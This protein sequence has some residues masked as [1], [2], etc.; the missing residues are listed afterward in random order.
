MS[1]GMS[2]IYMGILRMTQF[3]CVFM[4]LMFPAVKLQNT[5]S[6]IL[7]QVQCVLSWILVGWETWKYFYQRLSAK[8]QIHSQFGL[9]KQMQLLLSYQ[10]ALKQRLGVILRIKD[11]NRI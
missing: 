7:G 10:K 11:K 9:Q 2:N 1:K 8:E 4:L 3:L 6:R 5:K